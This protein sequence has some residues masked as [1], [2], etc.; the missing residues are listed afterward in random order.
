MAM[1]SKLARFAATF[2]GA[3]VAL[4]VWSGCSSNASTGVGASCNADPVSCGRGTTCW[5]TSGTGADLKLTCLP[6]NNAYGVGSVCE[7]S[8]D[9][10]TCGDGLTCDVLGPDAGGT[11]TFY[12]STARGL[13]CPAGFSCHVTHIGGSDGPAIELCRK[14]TS[15]TGDGGSGD[16]GTVPPGYLPDGGFDPNYDAGGDAGSKPI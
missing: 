12:C 2:A 4:A 8:L 13:Q 11:C 5:P 14:G 9:L 16:P 15:T 7:D 6:S 1:T 10:A 3:A